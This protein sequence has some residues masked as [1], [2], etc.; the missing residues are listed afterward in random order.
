MP[1]GIESTTLYHQGWIFHI[2]PTTTPVQRLVLLLHGWTG[3]ENSMAIIGRILPNGLY[4]ISPRGPVACPEGGYGWVNHKAGS[5]PD[6]A[7]F[8]PITDR[9]M[10]GLDSLLTTLQIDSPLLDLVGF[11]Q[12]AAMAYTLLLRYPQRIRKAACLSGFLPQPQPRDMPDLHGK[13][14][15]IAHGT[16]DETVPVEAS[17]QAHQLLIQAGAEVTFCETDTGHKLALS[18]SKDLHQFMQ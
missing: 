7:D 4:Q 3:D 6:L 16:Q 14:V 8:S 13:S 12:G 9:F 5:W 18:C 10:S 11:S 17:R 1:T 15:Y 2:Q